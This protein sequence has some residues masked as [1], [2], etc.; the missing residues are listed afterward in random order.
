MH[1]AA[2]ARGSGVKPIAVM[3]VILFADENGLTIIS[4]LDHVQ[5]LIRQEVASKSRHPFPPRAKMNTGAILSRPRKST[6][7]PIIPPTPIISVPII[8]DHGPPGNRL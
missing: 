5:R 2:V 4:A 1:R 6:L 8:S 3:S 7:T